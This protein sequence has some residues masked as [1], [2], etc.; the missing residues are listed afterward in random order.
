MP[1]NTWQQFTIPLTALGVADEANF[2]RFVIQDSIGSAQPTF[3]VDDISLI[4]TNN[5]ILP[6][7]NFS[8]IA[9]FR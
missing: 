2:T 9:S 6:Q 5:Y 4:A 7:P 3:Y 1:A 8:V